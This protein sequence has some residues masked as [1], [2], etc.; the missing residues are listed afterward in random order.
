LSAPPTEAEFFLARIPEHTP[1]AELIVFV[2]G[3]AGRSRR[4]T[5]R[6][7]DCSP[8]PVGGLQVDPG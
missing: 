1:I 6:A 5:P 3:V 7:R 8:R 2:A 4:T